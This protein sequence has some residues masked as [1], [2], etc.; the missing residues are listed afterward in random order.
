M[1]Q[2]SPLDRPDSAVNRPSDLRCHNGG[3]PPHSSP[4]LGPRMSANFFVVVPFSCLQSWPLVGSSPLGKKTMMDGF[5]FIAVLTTLAKYPLLKEF[6]TCSSLETFCLLPGGSDGG[7]ESLQAPLCGKH[8]LSKKRLK[9]ACIQ[10]RTSARQTFLLSRTAKTLWHG[11]APRFFCLEKWEN[12][13][14][15]LA[16]AEL[17]GEGVCGREASVQM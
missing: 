6:S 3:H 5:V 9:N 13:E 10:T 8:F 14:S 12:R 16:E 17:A 7:C 2:R 1:M 11:S 4:T 15:D